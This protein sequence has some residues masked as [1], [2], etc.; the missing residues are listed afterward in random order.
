MTGIDGGDGCAK[1]SAKTAVLAHLARLL[2]LPLRRLLQVA[3]KAAG[4]PMCALRALEELRETG[5]IVACGECGGS[6]TYTTP[7]KAAMLARDAG[8]YLDWRKP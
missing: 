7:V 4:D 1:A 5:H 3:T 2:P 8:Q 6:I